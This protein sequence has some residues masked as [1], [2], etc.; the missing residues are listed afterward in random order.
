MARRGFWFPAL[1]R[2]QEAEASSRLYG[3]W[4]P[5]E[6][7]RHAYATPPPSA[8]A[9]RLLRYNQR[10][11]ELPPAERR[12]FTRCANR[13]RALGVGEPLPSDEVALQIYE[14][15]LRSRSA[16]AALEQWLECLR[17]AGIEPPRASDSRWLPAAAGRGRLDRPAAVAIA[18]ADVEC[19]DRTDLVSRLAE[20]EARGQSEWMQGH[21]RSLVAQR[22]RLMEALHRA[23]RMIARLSG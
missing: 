14:S 18:I 20:I 8:A 5:T 11:S 6:A 10:F 4:L 22:Q 17:R 13:A 2:R 21:L 23:E 7:R 9:R 19:K 16:Q 15:A 1:D 3:V 12:A